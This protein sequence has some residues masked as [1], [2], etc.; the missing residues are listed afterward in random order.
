MNLKCDQ[1][2]KNW[3][4][5]V[6]P[7]WGYHQIIQTSEPLTW[8]LNIKMRSKYSVDSQ[9]GK[10][11]LLSPPNYLNKDTNLSH[12]SKHWLII[13]TRTH[14]HTHSLSLCAK[15]REVDKFLLRSTDVHEIDHT[16]LFLNFIFF[17]K[18]ILRRG[19]CVALT[20]FEPYKCMSE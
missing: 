5:Q 9:N 20:C 7:N 13:H 10:W 16:F 12:F 17:G 2:H 19:V 4:E 14:T 6:R 15:N 11:N 3:S 18:V 8:T 1:G